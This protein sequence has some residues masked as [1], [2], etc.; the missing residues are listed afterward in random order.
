MIMSRLSQSDLK[1]WMLVSEV[2]KFPAIWQTPKPALHLGKKR[3]A[4][5]IGRID[6]K[7]EGV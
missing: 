6:L 2:D 3:L 7:R 1:T 5:R 4:N